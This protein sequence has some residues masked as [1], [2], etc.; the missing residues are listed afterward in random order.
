MS[1]FV[2]S[3][4]DRC[5]N[6]YWR[7]GDGNG[8]M[9]PKVVRLHHGVLLVFSTAIHL[10]DRLAVTKCALMARHWHLLKEAVTGVPPAGICHFTS[11][12]YVCT[13]VRVVPTD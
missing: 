6:Y 12:C 9:I 11:V 3:W 5:E 7:F 2:S 10:Q 8:N 1:W 13:H 4:Y